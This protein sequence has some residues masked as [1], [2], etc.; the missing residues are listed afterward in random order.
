MGEN[1]LRS[2]ESDKEMYL[3]EKRKT[4]QKLKPLLGT[5]F[6]Q[7]DTDGTGTVTM[8][9]VR[10]GDLQL[11][12]EF[13]DKITIPC[14]L[15]LFH[16]I[17]SDKSGTISKDEWTESLLF[18]GLHEVPAETTR[19]LQL[20]RRQHKKLSKLEGILKALAA[21]LEHRSGPQEAAAHSEVHHQC[22]LPGA[23][24]HPT[25]GMESALHAS[26]GSTPT[27]TMS[28]ACW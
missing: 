20:I 7:L 10:E 21:D 14:I 11:P 1:A 19:I 3:T 27:P 8:Q 4:F 5:L 12:L 16:S 22:R 25:D 28:V 9:E 6:D 18:L 13:R 23:Q 2:V 17:D 24:Q 26:L 15:D